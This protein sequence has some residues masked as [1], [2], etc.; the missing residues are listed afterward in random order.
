M[1]YERRVWQD[2]RTSGPLDDRYPRSC[3]ADAPRVPAPAPE[4]LPPRCDRPI[5]PEKESSCRL[6]TARAAKLPQG[7]YR[8]SK[9]HDGEAEYRGKVAG[10]GRA[11]D[12]RADS[13]TR[14]DEKCDDGPR[15]QNEPI[16]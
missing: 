5:G 11:P 10:S 6:A 4:Y 2:A 7:V 15:I 12:D 13:G 1:R 8:K 9:H 3:S 14:A 16:R